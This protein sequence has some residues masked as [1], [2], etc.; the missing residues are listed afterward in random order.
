MSRGMAIITTASA[1]ATL[2]FGFLALGPQTVHGNIPSADRWI[3][4]GTLV[5]F[6]LAAAL[7]IVTNAAVRHHDAVIGGHELLE[8]LLPGSA[9]YAVQLPSS[10]SSAPEALLHDKLYALYWYMRHNHLRA[11]GLTIALA[12]EVLAIFSLALSV[13][14][15]LSNS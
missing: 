3:V 2:F 5:L 9:S 12:L 11:R 4:A 15:I 13:F 10:L 14:M 7:G 1:I 6:S 8:P